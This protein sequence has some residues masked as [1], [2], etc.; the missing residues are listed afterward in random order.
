M[1]FLKYFCLIALSLSSLSAKV[2]ARTAVVE[3][4]SAYLSTQNIETFHLYENNIWTTKAFLEGIANKSHP[5]VSEHYANETS[6]YLPMAASV[7]PGDGNRKHSFGAVG[8]AKAVPRLD[9]LVLPDGTVEVI[10]NTDT[11]LRISF[12][13]NSSQTFDEVLKAVA[14]QVK[15]ELY[16]FDYSP[17]YYSMSVQ[18]NF[19]PVNVNELKN[20]SV[21]Y[22]MP[23][24]AF[25]DIVIE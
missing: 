9:P 1:K 22:M 5:V 16:T 7:H 23:T 14:E 8:I 6:I 20:I 15:K 12:D 24:R 10:K 21:L 19:N 18:F 3:L 11:F 17:Y 4:E 25:S 13:I 2:A